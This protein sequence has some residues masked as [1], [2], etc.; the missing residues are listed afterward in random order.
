MVERLRSR[1]W[2]IFEEL[3]GRRLPNYRRSLPRNAHLPHPNGEQALFISSVETCL[4]PLSEGEL[5][6]RRIF[7][8]TGGPGTGKTTVVSHICRV[9][10]SSGLVC[11][12]CLSNW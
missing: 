3:A 2:L 11:V 7:L 6:C 1:R 5:D 9:C 10:G 4:V 8:L 12:V